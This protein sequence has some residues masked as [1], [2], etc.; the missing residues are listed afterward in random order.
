M[1]VVPQ[2]DLVYLWV[3]GNDPVHIEERKKHLGTWKS[4]D[5]TAIADYRW[6]D[7]GEL[8]LSITSARKFAPWIRKIF[9]VTSLA[10][11]PK[12][13]P[14][15][16]NTQQAPI[17]FVD[18]CDLLPLSAI[19][20]FNSQALEAN[21]H[22]IPNLSEQFLYANDDEMFGAPVEPW[23]FFDEVTG[24]PRMVPGELLP[25]PGR[26]F[27]VDVLPGW[28]SARCNNGLLLNRLF[29]PC[30]PPRQEA[31]HQIRPLLKSVFHTM[32]S[33]GIIR[34]HLVQTTNSRFRHHKN[35]E[36]VGLAMQCAKAWRKAGPDNLQLR[37]LYISWYDDTDWKRQARKLHKKRP[38]LICINDEQHKHHKEAVV[39]MQ[40]CVLTYFA[41]NVY[42]TKEEQ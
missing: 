20:T 14:E 25:A 21:L 6:Q 12:F 15:F 36:P 41:G 39:E 19:P 18:D 38:H 1:S 5:K 24:Y 22:Q 42:A 28:Y 3:D 23:D 34:N 9:I 4:R 30:I 32:W 10:Q 13:S 2:V 17:T 35:V 11:R 16:C 40:A 31:K 37:C 7:N 26:Q 27:S 29:G 8:F 33:I